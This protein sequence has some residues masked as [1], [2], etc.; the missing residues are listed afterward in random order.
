LAKTP[1]PPPRY[2]RPPSPFEVTGESP[3]AVVHPSAK[4]EDHV[5][6]DPGAVIGPRAGI[7]SGTLIGAT[8][9]IGPDV[10]IGRNCT[11]GASVTI[12]HAFIGDGVTIHTGC[13]IGQN[14]ESSGRVIIQDGCEI[15]AGTAI[16]RGASAD[17]VI[18]E[19][20]KI[21]NLVQI[22]NDAMVGRHCRLV[23]QSGVAGHVT[24]GDHVTLGRQAGVADYLTVGEGAEI[25]ARAGVTADVK[26][27]AKV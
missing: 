23:A 12:M 1:K 19:K 26:A 27:G 9:V 13:R 5:A 21:D 18:G 7:G 6:I 10:Q 15:G 25:S 11:I 4:I 22:G 3:G 2:V 16:D 14:G 8:A 17:T 20:T 24:L